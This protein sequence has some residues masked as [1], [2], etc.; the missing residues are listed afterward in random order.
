M[1]HGQGVETRANGDIY[2]GAWEND[3]IQGQGNFTWV[4]GDK[5]ESSVKRF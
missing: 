1:R 3:I 4:N 2:D 5:Y